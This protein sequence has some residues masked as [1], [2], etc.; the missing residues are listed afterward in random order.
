MTRQNDLQYI[1]DT[2]LINKLELISNGIYKKAGMLG[3]IEGAV[4]SWAKEHIDTSS[5]E[6]IAVSLGKLL[7]PAILGSISPILGL[8][9][10]AV[11]ELAGFSI[12][13]II[14][15]ILSSVIDKVKSGESITTTDV[16]SSAGALLSGGST[17][18]FYGIR[19]FEKTGKLILI[20]K[21]AQ[22]EKYA[23][24]SNWLASLFRTLFVAGPLGKHQG[25][26]LI[27]GIATWLIK[28][29]LKGA[30]LLALTGGVASLVGLKNNKQ[31]EHTKDNIEVKHD[32]L[33]FPSPPNNL[34]ASGRGESVHKN[35]KDNIWWMPING[36]IEN[37]LISFAQDVYPEL[38]GKDKE[39]K[40][41]SYFNKVVSHLKTMVDKNYVEMPLGI[42]TIKDLVDTF[43]GDVE[44]YLNKSKIAMFYYTK[45]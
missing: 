6:S 23:A 11:Q 43:S 32:S 30:G 39:I 40:L 17:D 7:E 1:S 36:S 25:F 4:L 2:Q 5:P 26:S 38:E 45:F 3:G 41:S 18:L 19:E 20:I 22:Q 21:T 42:T 24:G 31:E 12:T 28:T 33:P 44:N 35:D 13:S 37:T 15:R 16:N 10:A 34:K 27:T 29:V 9:D 14:A 8:L